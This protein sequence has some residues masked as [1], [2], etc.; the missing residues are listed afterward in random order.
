LSEEA[1]DTSQTSS[2]IDRTQLSDYAEF[3][4][5]NHDNIRITEGT[6]PGKA[7]H[8]PRRSAGLITLTLPVGHLV[9]RHVQNQSVKVL[10]QTAR[11]G[12]DDSDRKLEMPAEEQQ[13]AQNV[14]KINLLSAFNTKDNAR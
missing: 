9:S 1:N 6:A 3:Y 2:I 4:T 8:A 5:A 7:E 14:K 12:D 11:V 13:R 10:S